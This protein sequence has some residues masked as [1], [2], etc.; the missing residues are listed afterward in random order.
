[1]KAKKFSLMVIA[2]LFLA[3]CLQSCLDDGDDISVRYPNALVT[4]KTS[5]SDGAFYLQLDE[6]TTLYPINLDKSPF[7]DKEVRALVNYREDKAHE[8]H[9]YSKAVYVNWIDSILTKQTRVTLGEEDEKTFGKDPLEIYRDWVT[10]AEDGYLTLRFT[11]M[12]GYSGI[13]HTVNLITGVNPDDPY[14]V[15]LRHNANGDMGQRRADGLVAFNLSELPDTE[16]QTV[17]LTLRWQSFL[18]EKTTQFDYCT[19]K[20]TQTAVA[21]IA[22][23]QP[24][25]AIQ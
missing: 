17:K 2:L 1:M 5:D 12:W 4:A 21:N 7:G 10:I 15:V 22:D 23:T 18:G 20:T 6:N 9:G 19:R 11:A 14:E 24:T 16:G 8:S 13:A 3:P 25:A